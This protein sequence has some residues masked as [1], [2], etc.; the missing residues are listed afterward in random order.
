MTEQLAV[1]K[2]KHWPGVVNA[3]VS[4]EE[5]NDGCQGYPE[6]GTPGSEKASSENQV[7]YKIEVTEK[8]TQKQKNW[9]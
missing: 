9:A 4:S 7:E 5:K 2:E 1:I 6:A 8:L 3:V